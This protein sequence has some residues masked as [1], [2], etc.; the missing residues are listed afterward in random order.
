M[1]KIVGVRFRKSGMIKYYD[2]NSVEDENL[3]IGSHVMV[4]SDKGLMY[5]TVMMPPREL[6][7]NDTH[8][9]QPIER[10][11]TPEDDL[12][13]H[14]NL[15]REAAASRICKERIAYHGL[16][17]KLVETE[18][19][20]DRGKLLFYFTADGRVDFRELVKDLAGEFRTRIELRQ[21]GVR[22]EAK[23]VGG[24]GICG[25]ELCCSTYMNDF[26]PVSIKMA[27]E[28]NLSLNPVKIS[29][30]C[31]RLMCCLK[32]EEETYE[33]LNSQLP[34]MG[35]S[36]T[37]IDGYEGVV[38]EVN[39]LRQRVKVTIDVGDEK[40][41]KEY[42]VKELKFQQGHVI[43]EISEDERELFIKSNVDDNEN[44][45]DDLL[46]KAGITAS[47]D[48][49]HGKKGGGG[50]PKSGRR[51]KDNAPKEQKKGGAPFYKDKRQ[52]RV[53]DGVKETKEK[54]YSKKFNNKKKNFSRKSRHKGSTDEG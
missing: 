41:L 10:A 16:D 19:S 4:D 52:E 36:V 32:N 39:V 44:D 8:S 26:V 23:L 50:K 30:A 46:E 48:M 25:R 11:A 51:P 43:H 33:Y 40:E 1:S 45:L 42:S 47:S 20:F 27:K 5:G 31:G 29:G 2:T 6:D 53:P 3:S 15:E 18:Y 14:D 22:D 9:F 38:S 12:I 17:M 13:W 7:E 35:S 37:T 54:L 24:F 28:Q 21:I 49:G 34:N